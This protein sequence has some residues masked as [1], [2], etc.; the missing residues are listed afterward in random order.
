MWQ[1][2]KTAKYKSYIYNGNV[3]EIMFSGK[4]KTNTYEDNPAF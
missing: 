2:D 3:L 4:L 1:V